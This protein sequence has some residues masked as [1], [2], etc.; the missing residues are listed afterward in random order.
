MFNS[1]ITSFQMPCDF[2][3]EAYG[4]REIYLRRRPLSALQIRRIDIATVIAIIV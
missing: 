3:K 4:F 2:V 1:H